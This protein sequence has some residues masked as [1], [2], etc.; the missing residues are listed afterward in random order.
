MGYGVAM[1]THS[2]RHL[3]EEARETLSL[4][5]TH[6]YSFRTMVQILGQSPNT[7]KPVRGLE[8]GP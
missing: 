1:R 7:L 2:Y 6:G 3:R 8:L 4:G 5:L